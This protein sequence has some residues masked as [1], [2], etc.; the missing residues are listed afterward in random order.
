MERMDMMVPEMISGRWTN[1][2]LVAGKEERHTSE[3][4][5]TILAPYRLIHSCVN[6]STTLTY[7]PLTETWS[8]WYAC[9]SQPRTV[10]RTP[11]KG[12]SR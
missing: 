9:M 1:L 11:V 3:C 12:A 7:L 8:L 2:S 5:T 10:Q 4:H 6:E